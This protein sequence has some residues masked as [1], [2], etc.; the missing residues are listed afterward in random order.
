[1][2]NALI[3]PHTAPPKTLVHNILP[4]FEQTR[5]LLAPQTT[6][7]GCAPELLEA[8]LI[9]TVDSLAAGKSPAAQSEVS[10]LL[11]QWEDWIAVQRSTGNL[12]MLKAGVSA[13]APPKETVRSLIQEIKTSY[14]ASSGQPLPPEHPPEL[15]LHLA[16]VRDLVAQDVETGYEAL[17]DGQSALNRSLGLDLEDAAPAEF[18]Q[19]Q[20]YDAPPADYRLLE[21][22]MLEPRLSAWARLVPPQALHGAVPVCLGP[23][24]AGLLAERLKASGRRS[25]AGAEEIEPVFLSWPPRVARMVLPDLGG[26]SGGAMV[27]LLGSLN[28]SGV[29]SGLRK[30][31][32]EIIEQAA[33]QPVSAGLAGELNDQAQILADELGGRLKPLKRRIALEICSLPGLDQDGLLALMRGEA[34]ATDAQ[35]S[36]VLASVVLV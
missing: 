4:W 26:L 25:A 33:S 21:E 14:Q 10:R 11:A 31:L 6:A 28:K 34:P 8:G 18:S 17:E 32:G 3:V 19:V 15:L 35:D 13:G 23:D 9:E 22:E 29:L 27:E 20:P 7:P 24:A 16:H 5:M 30:G 36:I 12:D 2:P 1:M